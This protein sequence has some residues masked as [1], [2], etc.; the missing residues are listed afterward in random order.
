MLVT[1][2][3]D[4]DDRVRLEETS[5][6]RSEHLLVACCPDN[7]M[8]RPRLGFILIDILLDELRHARHEPFPGNRRD[9]L[10]IGVVVQCRLVDALARRER[11]PCHAMV[12]PCNLIWKRPPSGGDLICSITIER[13]MA[14]ID[15]ESIEK[16]CKENKGK[17]VELVF[18]MTAGGGHGLQAVEESRLPKCLND[19]VFIE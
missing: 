8:D 2:F 15:E 10:P 17:R 1:W 19:H 13:V 18:T 3:L 12:I 5:L 6:E 9:I 11:G 14:R 16:E 7:G 4:P